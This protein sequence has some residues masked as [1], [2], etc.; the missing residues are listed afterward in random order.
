MASMK[1]LRLL[2]V[3]AFPGFTLKLTF[4]NGQVWRP[5]PQVMA[6]LN[7]TSLSPASRLLQVRFTDN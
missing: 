4:V 3:Q 1:R 5:R 6:A 7:V 2:A